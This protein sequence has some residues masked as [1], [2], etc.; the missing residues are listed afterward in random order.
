LNIER[1]NWPTPATLI[2]RHQKGESWRVIGVAL[3]VHRKAV[4]RYV[5][6]EIATSN[7]PSE[8]KAA[9]KSDA[10]FVARMMRAIKTRRETAKIGTFIDTSPTTAP[11]IHAPA[12][13][14]GCGSPA[15]DC[16]G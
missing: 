9:I 10:A 5:R 7:V 4:Q 1:A 2:A 13:F 11:L 14:S 8:K 3:G 16:V 15:A 12:L 6:G